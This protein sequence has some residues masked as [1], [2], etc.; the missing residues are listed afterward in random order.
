MG[1]FEELSELY[2]TA[3]HFRKYAEARVDRPLGMTR[4]AELFMK[5]SKTVEKQRWQHRSL[6]QSEQNFSTFIRLDQ[7]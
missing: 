2:D 6:M 4:E 5:H 3:N 7:S 1:L